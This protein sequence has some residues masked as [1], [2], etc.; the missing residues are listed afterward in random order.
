VRSR[1][2][3]EN[4]AAFSPSA[5][6]LADERARA[7]EAQFPLRTNMQSLAYTQAAEFA[8]ARRAM[9]RATSTT[10]AQHTSGAKSVPR[11]EPFNA[12]SR[13]LLS[14]ETQ[15]L[16]RE[17]ALKFDAVELEANATAEPSQAPRGQAR[18]PHQQA[19]PPHQHQV[20]ATNGRTL[21][22]SSRATIDRVRG[23]FRDR[24]FV[25]QHPSNVPAAYVRSANP[26]YRLRVES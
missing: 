13:V 8:G 25:S 20:R 7:S 24:K 15:T 2:S 3:I 26:A 1:A 10:S 22:E 18:P 21:D 4:W 9:Q 11:T 17:H 19:R 6:H 12:R 14:T 5:V 16:E 23:S